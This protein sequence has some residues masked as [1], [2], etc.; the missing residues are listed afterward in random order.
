LSRALRSRGDA[1]L[2]AAAAHEAEGGLGR[3][4]HDLAELA[5]QA[6]L[7]GAGADVGLDEQQGAA[8][9]GPAE[10]GDDAGGRDLGGH[11]VVVAG[12][13][14]HAQELGLVEAGV[15]GLAL[16]EVHGDV[17]EQRGEL[18]LEVADAG[19]AG[20]LGREREQ[21]VVVDLDAR[22][23]RGRSRRAAWAAGA[24]GRSPASPRSGVAAQRD[25]LEAVAED[26]GIA[27]S[28][29]AV[30]RKITRERS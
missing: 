3:L 25:D 30:H 9:G 5:G 12:R 24:G 10:A 13:A 20:V 22:R 28:S 21:D 4:L 7:A 19:L 17:A 16:G 29:L 18:T 2:G 11:L 6:D 1:E 23:R 26:V 15:R 27:D 14:E 8:D